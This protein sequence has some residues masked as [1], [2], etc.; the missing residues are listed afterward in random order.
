MCIK[1]LQTIRISGVGRK[2]RRSVIRMTGMG[3][4]DYVTIEVADTTAAEAFYT[5]AFEVGSRV[6][7]RASQAPTTGF[8]GFTMSLV[9]SRPATVNSLIDSAL[10]AGAT[11][12][13]PPA[14]S[15]WG[16]GGVVQAPDGTIWTVAS[17]SKKDAG[18]ANRQIDAIVL[19]LGVTDVAG[20]K[21]FYLQHGLT[22]AKSFGTKYVELDTGPIKL[23][24]NK[25]GA[26]AKTAGVSPDGAGSHRLMIG[27]D[28]GALTDP[29]GFA[30]EAPVH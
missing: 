3:T 12:L 23:T 25:R 2:D 19:Q 13:K 24:L 5:A 15:L 22:V 4:I 14:K 1:C 8:R 16:Y 17:S 9:V 28:L 18:P 7:V 6:R 10:A 30:W 26:L 21:Q 27:G 29:D 11:A 20:S